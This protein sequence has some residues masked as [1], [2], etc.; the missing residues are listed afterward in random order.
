[1][2][3]KYANQIP[4]IA[5]NIPD[6]DGVAKMT[7]QA[8]GQ[9]VACIE[10]SVGNGHSLSNM[11]AVKYAAVGVAGAALAFSALGA[12]GAG[13]H[14][15]ASPSSPTFGEVIGWFQGMA[16]N[17]MMSVN[18]PQVYQGFTTNFGFSTGLVPWS[19]MQSA[20]DNFRQATGGNLTD[21][22]YQYLKNNVTLVHTSDSNSTASTVKRA[23]APMILWMRQDAT[24]STNDTTTVIGNS[25]T[26][27]TATG[28][29][30]QDKFVSGI[31]SYVEQLSI[32]SAN[33]FMTVLLIWCC[34]MAALIV[35]IL[36]LK[37]ILE[38][39]AMLGNIPKSMESWRKRY[40]WRLAK[41]LTNLVLLL[42]GS[43][44][45]YCVYQF[46]NGDSWAAKI[47]AAVTFSLFTCVLA[48]FSWRI[49]SKAHEYKKADGDSS[50]L[51]DDKDTWIKYS[52]FYENYKQGYW[53]LFVPTIVYMFARG[54]VIAGA[55]GHGL[56]QTG[57]QLIV[58]SL[59]LGLLL[60]ARPYQRKSGTWINVFIQ[61]VRVLSVICILVF[62]EELGISQT[63][64]TIT[65]VVLIVVQ[66]VLTAVLAILIA[67]N[68]L[69]GCIR[70]NPHR[71]QRKA[72]EKL[73]TRGD[74]D[75]LTPLDARNSLLM[76][77]MAQHGDDAMYKAPLVAA[78]PVA[79]FSDR[80]TAHYDPVRASSPA[81]ERRVSRYRDY[82][83]HRRL[84][85]DAGEMGHQRDRSVSQSPSL[86][87]EPRLPDFDFGRAH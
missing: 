22:N 17:G 36:L 7:I 63:T 16:L 75:A 26:N 15:G 66:S 35:L 24:V 5:F 39:W 46:T 18:Y 55:N 83:D 61:V 64:K 49:Y 68:A 43:W 86:S 37:V 60:W 29:T 40:W 4:S 44:T 11:P 30:K 84:V 27:S 78:G 70:E 73:L 85:S 69:I 28:N 62:V 74:L 87:R 76:E 82:D 65:G 2:P 53:W 25:T 13:A 50:R 79:P 21:N 6:L 80:K 38:A 52:L 41:A 72:R 77:P 45:L 47:L 34:V 56:I 58:E 33:T 19:S 57:G 32:P 10:S 31:Q 3:E 9:D 81:D 59:F 8:N 54:A 12:V 23:L 42:Y 48:G 14:P 51:Y 67:V 1:M 20:I 71:Q